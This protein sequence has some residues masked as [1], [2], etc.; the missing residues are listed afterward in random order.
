MKLNYD[1]SLE[2]SEKDF[3]NLHKT[4]ITLASGLGS[5]AHKIID[6]NE[7][8]RVQESHKDHTEKLLKKEKEDK[9]HQVSSQYETKIK[10]LEDQIKRLEKLIQRDNSPKDYQ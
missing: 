9:L 4:L 1:Y 5:I 2:Y 7:R 6:N 8:A 3:E 10:S